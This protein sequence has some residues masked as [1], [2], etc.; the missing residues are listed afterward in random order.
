MSKISMQNHE[1]NDNITFIS[2]HTKSQKFINMITHIYKIII[3][4]DK[5]DIHYKKLINVAFTNKI[6]T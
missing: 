5:N 2:K 1:T 6:I 4:I 3:K